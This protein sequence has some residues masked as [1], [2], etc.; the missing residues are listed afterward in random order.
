MGKAWEKADLRQ[1]EAAAKREKRRLKK[2][3]RAATE[4][5]RLEARAMEA[6][7]RREANR[8]RRERPGRE[9]ARRTQEMLD[10]M[11]DTVRSSPEQNPAARNL[12]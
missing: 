6:I 5:Q 4:D 3:H 7:Q 2:Q 1:A 9:A 10:S 12:S 8:R 11:I